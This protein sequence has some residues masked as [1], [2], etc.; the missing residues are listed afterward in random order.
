MRTGEHADDFASTWT[1]TAQDHGEERRDGH[2]GKT[3]TT[4]GQNG[5]PEHRS[6]LEYVKVQSFRA[7]REAEF[8]AIAEAYASGGDEPWR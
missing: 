6:R 5:P 4:P 3:M 2:R 7:L 8:R 1:P